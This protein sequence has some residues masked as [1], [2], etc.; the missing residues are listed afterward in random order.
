MSAFEG[1]G[2][3]AA[4][5]LRLL[6]CWDLHDDVFEIQAKAR[7]EEEEERRSLADFGMGGGLWKS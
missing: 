5:K 6:R 2:M 4:N 3:K 1:P 7:K